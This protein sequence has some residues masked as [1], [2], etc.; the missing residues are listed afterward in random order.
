MAE[1]IKAKSKTNDRLGSFKEVK[2]D[3]NYIWSLGHAFSYTRLSESTDKEHEFDLLD[4]YASRAKRIAATYARFYLELEKGCDKSKKGRFYWMALGAL[5]SK[6]VGCILDTWQLNASFSGGFLLDMPIPEEYELMQI[7]EGLGVGNLWLFMDVATWHWGYVN[8][9][10]HYF[11]GMNCEPKRNTD[12]LLDNCPDSGVEGGVHTTVHKELPWASYAIPKINKLQTTAYIK[13]G[14]QLV[15]KIQ[16]MDDD[17]DEKPDI[18]LEHL[19][20]VANHEQE[21]ILQKLIYEHEGFKNWLQ[22]ERGIRA[23]SIKAKK[24]ALERSR[25]YLKELEEAEHFWE[26]AWVLFSPEEHKAIVADFAKGKVKDLLIDYEFVFAASCKTDDNSLKNVASDNIELETLGSI[27][28]ANKE[29]YKS[30]M[31]W[32][33]AVASDFHRLMQKDRP[34]YM[35]SELH[36]IAGWVDEP[37]HS[38]SCLSPYTGNFE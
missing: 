5:A 2:V 31:G 25:E 7:A 19:I 30:R 28:D 23:W 17:N 37:D 10:E 21:M 3:C 26:K 4:C 15:E 14:M 11:K 12:S 6:T 32:I 22:I 35:E 1:C 13:K 38:W 36:T 34:E 33:G 18:Q 20:E 29:G 16:N 24:R 27:E 9:P 8:F